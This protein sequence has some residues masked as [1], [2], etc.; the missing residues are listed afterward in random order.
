[1]LATPF[2]HLL[3]PETF[4]VL[5]TPLFLSKPT[6]NPSGNPVGSSLK[7]YSESDHLLVI[8]CCTAVAQTA[9]ISLRITAVVSQLFHP[10]F[11][12]Y[13]Q[14]IYLLKHKVRSCC[15]S[16]HNPLASCLTQ[17]E[18]QVLQCPIEALPDVISFSHSGLLPVLLKYTNLLPHQDLHPCC[19]IAGMLFLRYFH[20]P[21]IPSNPFLKCHLLHEAFLGHTV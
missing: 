14:R 11:L 2:F 3:K 5:M 13:S 16:A 1:M 17:N 8:S 4:L 18:S 21:F 20:D 15:S 9:I 10:C 12:S 7:I 6:S 19:S